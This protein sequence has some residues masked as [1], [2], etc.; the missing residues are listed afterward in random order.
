[1]L[2]ES[3]VG[4]D[5]IRPCMV[6]LDHVP[7]SGPAG[8]LPPCGWKAFD[9]VF[10]LPP[11]GGKLSSKARLMRG[12]SIGQAGRPKKGPHVKGGCHRRKAVAGGSYVEWF[13]LESP[14]HSAPPPFSKGGFLRDREGG[15]PTH[16]KRVGVQILTTPAI[17]I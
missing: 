9:R 10:R 3:R 5:M 16:L 2:Q 13:V 7:S 1:M 4:A 11:S 6:H 8:H 17:W 15:A 12:Q 14:R